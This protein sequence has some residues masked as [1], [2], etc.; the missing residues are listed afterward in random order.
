VFAINDATLFAVGLTPVPEPT[1]ALGLAA[2]A[3]A[4]GATRIRRKSSGE[5]DR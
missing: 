2:F 1:A 3:V 4:V 5:T